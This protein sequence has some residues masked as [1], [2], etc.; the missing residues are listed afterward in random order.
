MQ[1]KHMVGRGELS[2]KKNQGKFRKGEKTCGGEVLTS[3][4]YRGPCAF[5]EVGTRT[6]TSSRQN[7]ILKKKCTA[8]VSSQIKRKRHGQLLIKYRTSAPLT[9]LLLRD[10]Y[11]FC[12]LPENTWVLMHTGQWVTKIWPCIQP[13]S[14]PRR[15]L[16]GLPPLYR[17]HC[18]LEVLVGRMC[19]IHQ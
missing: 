10:W 12:R 9:A 19:S 14:R 13:T 8:N 17:W 4:H 3:I 11:H 5:P 15:L 18:V 2:L 6:K 1:S 7:R 16:T